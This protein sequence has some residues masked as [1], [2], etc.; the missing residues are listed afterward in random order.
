MHHA[1]YLVIRTVAVDLNDYPL[2]RYFHEE[3]RNVFRGPVLLDFLEIQ[4]DVRL[5]GEWRT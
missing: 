5:S 2:Q 3:F 4:K 1:A